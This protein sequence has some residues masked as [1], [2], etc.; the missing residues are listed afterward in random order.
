[1]NEVSLEQVLLT[2]TSIVPDRSRVIAVTT[3]GND[4]CFVLLQTKPHMYSVSRRRTVNQ[5]IE[6]VA[7]KEGTVGSFMMSDKGV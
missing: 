2:M 1:M 5:R 3:P 7:Y 4:T 6:K